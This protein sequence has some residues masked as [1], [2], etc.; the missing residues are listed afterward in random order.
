MS[1]AA[2][3]EPPRRRHRLAKGIG[4][5]LLLG[6]TAAA[7]TYALGRYQLKSGEMALVAYLGRHVATVREPGEHWR[8]PTP[9]GRVTIAALPVEERLDFG[10]ETPESPER[11]PAPTVVTRDENTVQV[12]FS[13]VYRVRDPV[14][15]RYRVA[16]PEA[17]LRGVSLAA[18][19]R[20]AAERTLEQLR[21]DPPALLGEETR[22]RVGR[23]LSA[24]ACGMEVRSVQVSAPRAPPAA[25]AA[26]EAVSRAAEGRDREVAAATR[27]RE[28]ELAAASA[29]AVREHEAARADYDAR[30]AEATGEAESFRAL[31]VEYNKQPELV[32]TRLFL[33]TMEAVLPAA[34]VLVMEPGVQLPAVS[35]PTPAPNAAA[36]A[37]RE[38]S[39]P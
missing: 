28:R 15:E 12:P 7:W 31:A 24:C 5:I 33:E 37:V 2:G 9:L 10:M 29:E 26:F 6:L 36:P 4:F 39:A 19:R 30:I 8:W 38:D 18:L 1:G 20:V 11:A 23:A 25:Q 16:D 17:L 34:R 35:A 32:R 21:A 27:E 14:A 13:V 3:G 22:N